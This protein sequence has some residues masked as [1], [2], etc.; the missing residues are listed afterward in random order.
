MTL[1]SDACPHRKCDGTGFIVTLREVKGYGYPLE[2][3]APCVCHD[4]ALKAAMLKRLLDGAEI[5]VDLHG[6]TFDSFDPSRAPEQFRRVMIWATGIVAGTVTH[7]LLLYGP[8]KGA[9]KTHLAASA[10]NLIV[11]HKPV[12]FAVG[13]DVAARTV[14]QPQEAER[15]IEQ[16]TKAPV[17]FVDDLGQADDGMAKWRRSAAQQTWFRVLNAREQAGRPLC[18]TS[19]LASPGEFA[20]SIGEAPASRLFGMC[21]AVGTVSFDGLTDYRL[22]DWQ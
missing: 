1:S 3:A 17:L 2:F 13:P 22:K 21:K 11:Q 14:D 16:M 12:L 8:G 9:G 15:L 20:R 10:A 4:E 7:S 19:N 5:P 6:R 18:V